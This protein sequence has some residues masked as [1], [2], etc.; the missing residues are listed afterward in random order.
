MNH[1]VARKPIF[2]VSGFVR[3]KQASGA[4]VT[5]Y[6]YFERFIRSFIR[7]NEAAYTY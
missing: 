1:V 6:E 3:L 2:V 5:M 7:A 4:T